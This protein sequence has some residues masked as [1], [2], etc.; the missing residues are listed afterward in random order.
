MKEWLA[1]CCCN[2][3]PNYIVTMLWLQ[4]AKAH[5]TEMLK[6]NELDFPAVPL[7]MKL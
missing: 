4:A 6:L 5:K 2:I 7:K 3:E 1:G